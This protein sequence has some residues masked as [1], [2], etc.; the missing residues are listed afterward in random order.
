MNQGITERSVLAMGD[1]TGLMY[2]RPGGARGARSLPTA[3]LQPLLDS[4]NVLEHPASCAAAA[5][6]ARDD[7][8]FVVLYRDND[9]AADLAGFEADQARYRR[10]FENRA[11]V[12]YAPE[13]VPCAG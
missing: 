13:P 10:V 8:R 3:G 11:V 6:I 4:D 12:I 7:V 1:Y 9:H 2:Y 5:S